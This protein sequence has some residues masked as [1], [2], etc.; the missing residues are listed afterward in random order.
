MEPSESIMHNF[1]RFVQ[2]QNKL[3]GISSPV[4]NAKKVRAQSGG[5][6]DKFDTVPGLIRELKKERSDAKVML[7]TKEIQLKRNH[8]VDSSDETALVARGMKGNKKCTPYGRN[9][10]VKQDC[11]GNPE[12]AKYK[13]DGLH[14]GLNKSKNRGTKYNCG[15]H[16]K[17]RDD[18]SKES[19]QVGK[20]Y[21]TFLAC[22]PPHSADESDHRER[23]GDGY[24]SLLAKCLSTSS[25]A[26]GDIKDK[27]FIDSGTSANMCNNCDIFV[28][29]NES[30][31]SNTASVVDGNQTEVNGIGVVRGHAYFDEKE[32]PVEMKDA[33]FIEGLMCNLISASR[34]RRIGCRLTFDT[35]DFGECI[36]LVTHKQSKSIVLN[37]YEREDGL[38]EIETRLEKVA[39]PKSMAT[40]SALWVAGNKASGMDDL[41]TSVIVTSRGQFLWWM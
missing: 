25:D 36:C 34:L 26:L 12:S 10:H 27:W 18:D 17:N 22:L 30:D 21:A 4:E 3:N 8:G 20:G 13:P 11:F 6:R 40:V 1:N 2:L 38:Y 15:Q 32:V 7:V 9:G 31:D 16:N 23:V 39:R 14:E 35:D 29:L 33:L 28:D 5:L 24:A 41:I 37:G 19:E